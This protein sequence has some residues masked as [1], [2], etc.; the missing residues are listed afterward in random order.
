MTP[1]IILALTI[2]M[3]ATAFLSGI[4]GMAGGMI[5]I[6]VLL[7]LLPLPAAMV[8]HAVTQ[9][10][11]NAWRAILWWP[12]ILW[13]A[14]AAYA[15]GCALALLAWSVWRYTPSTPVA[16]LMLGVTPF[17]ARAVPDS[18]KPDPDSAVQGT[19]YGTICMT[20]LLL[21]GVSG[22]LIDTY[23]LGG[24]L[25]RRQIV[26]TKAICQ[27]F[28]HAA[29]LLY[30]GMLIDQAAALDPLMAALAIAASM[31]G[32]TLA[33]RVLEAMSDVQYRLWANR[34][35]TTIAGYYVIYGS[36]LLLAR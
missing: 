16:L 30:F 20:L 35:I 10:A 17:M 28:G 36:Y 27:V 12:H 32:T 6:G 21:T 22:P 13:R 31:I 23:F 9:M 25:D 29:K 18:F 26:A 24:K 14:A 11:S 5:L 15:A 33:R 8:L 3:V 34:I 19:L 1:A 7:F 2:T 4:F